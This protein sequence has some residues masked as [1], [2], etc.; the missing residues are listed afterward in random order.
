MNILQSWKGDYAPKIMNALEIDFAIY[1]NKEF[2][3]GVEKM[4]E[5]ISKTNFSWISS[6]LFDIKT[7]SLVGQRRNSKNELTVVPYKI[8]NHKLSTRSTVKVGIFG[9]GLSIFETFIFEQ[10]FWFKND[11]TIIK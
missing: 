2:D 8:F 11:R 4:T 9:L 10:I 1:G 7:N 6:N 3:H 5:L